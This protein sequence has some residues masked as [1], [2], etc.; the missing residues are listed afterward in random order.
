MN[1][2]LRPFSLNDLDSLV[3]YANN[4]QI[5][6]NMTNKFPHPYTEKDGKAFIGYANAETPHRILAIEVEGKAAGGI[7]VHPQADIQC[8]N[9]EMGYWLAEP[10]WGKGII[11][12][13]IP[14]MLEYGFRSWDIDRIFARPFGTNIASQRVLEK[15]GFELEARLKRTL[16]KNDEYIDELIYGFRKEKL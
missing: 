10:Y 9:A 16:F 11:S 13:A 4:Y 12:R 1:F 14:L 6:R 8:R 15:C 3:R 2:H 5:A 7:G